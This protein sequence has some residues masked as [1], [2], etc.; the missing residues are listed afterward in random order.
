MSA[1]IQTLDTIHSIQY[2]EDGS[3]RSM[4]FEHKGVEYWYYDGTYRLSCPNEHLG[5]HFT[6]KSL[7]H[8]NELYVRTGDGSWLTVHDMFA[9]DMAEHLE[10]VHIR[11]MRAGQLM[12]ITTGVVLDW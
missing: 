9:E 5:C 11:A 6:L 10:C 8:P 4:L 3:V 12:D 1:E 2:E 7:E